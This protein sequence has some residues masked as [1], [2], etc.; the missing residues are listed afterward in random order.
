M[1]E[2]DIEEAL[3]TVND[4]INTVLKALLSDARHTHRDDDIELRFVFDILA[5]DRRA[6][7]NKLFGL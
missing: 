3:E 7:W 4:N 1:S 2:E 5:A 6:L